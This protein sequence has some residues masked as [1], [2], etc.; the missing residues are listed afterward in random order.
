MK[1]P[2]NYQ[3]FAV[4]EGGA[5]ERCH[6]IPHH[7][8]YNIAQHSWGVAVLIHQLFRDHPKR[9][10][11]I[12]IALFHDVPERWT[13]DMPSTVKHS[14]KTLREDMERVERIIATKLDIPC[15]HSA[16]PDAYQMFKICDMLDLFLWAI[17]ESANGNKRVEDMVEALVDWF[18]EKDRAKE[19][20]DG[21]FD[22]FSQK[23][24][25]WTRTQDRE[26]L[27]Q[28]ASLTDNDER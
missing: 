26:T 21:F 11:A 19:L 28:L 2:S 10:E 23:L 16:S 24:R 6:V 1:Y 4:R 5:V 9:N 3:I 22:F 25:W 13:G 20:P 17:E 12:E 8:S 7:G 27:G 15:E 14:C 18:C